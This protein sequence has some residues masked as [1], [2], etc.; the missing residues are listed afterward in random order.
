MKAIGLI[1]ANYS[2]SGFGDLTDNRTLASLP[3]GGRYRL[4]DFALS[5]M[6]NSGITTVGVI[7]AYNSGSLIDHIGSGGPWSL[8]RKSG[9]MFLMPGSVYGVRAENGRFLLRDFITNKKFFERDDADYVIIS[10]SSDVYNMDYKPL[11]EFH[12]QSGRPMTMVY[13]K[14][15]KGE[16]VKGLFLHADEKGKV[17]QITNTSTGWSNYFIDTFIVDRKYILEFMDWFKA[18]D[19]MDMLHIIMDNIEKANIGMFEFKGYFGRINNS[20]EFLR[21]NQDFLDYDMRNEVFCD[22]ERTIFTKA[23]DEAPTGFLE[24]AEVRNSAIAAGCRIEG[25]VENSIIFRSCEIGKGA[26]VKNS[27]IMMHGIIGE[28]ALLDN[29]IC[30]KYV[31]INPG[32]KIYGGGGAPITIGKENNV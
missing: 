12:S 27:I 2:G 23:Q 30:D 7:C 11:I 16:E 9:G 22:P 5:N 8:S 10:G 32:V 26:V 29:V 21:V 20:T 4:I 31:T 28:G 25:R 13:K 15:P 24:T 14:L 17:T 19:Y 6:V 3:Y 1:S 18:I